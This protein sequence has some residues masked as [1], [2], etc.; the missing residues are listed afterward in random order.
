MSKNKSPFKSHWRTSLL[1]LSLASCIPAIDR[2]WTSI[3]HE[4]GWHAWMPQHP[5]KVSQQWLTS[6]AA[7]AMA[8]RLEG[9]M[10]VAVPSPGWGV[11]SSSGSAQGAAGFSQDGTENTQKLW[12]YSSAP[13]QGLYSSLTTQLEDFP[14]TE[15]RRK[16]MSSELT[17]TSVVIWQHTIQQTTNQRAQCQPLRSQLPPEQ[18]WGPAQHNI[19]IPQT[20]SGKCQ[21]RL[22]TEPAFQTDPCSSPGGLGIVE[23]FLSRPWGVPKDCPDKQNMLQTSSAASGGFCCHPH[24]QSLSK[25]IYSVSLSRKKQG[26]RKSLFLLNSYSSVVRSD[27]HTFSSLDKYLSTLFYKWLWRQKT[28]SNLNYMSSSNQKMA[29]RKN[30]KLPSYCC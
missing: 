28:C 8:I 23:Q 10:W 6:G 12:F 24:T 30:P 21:V 26:R 13:K 17:I 25:D 18:S 20:A 9:E 29:S 15:Q 3:L 16:I 4:Q 2:K 14:L 22:L 1:L 11:P 5:L 19:D 7:E 27:T